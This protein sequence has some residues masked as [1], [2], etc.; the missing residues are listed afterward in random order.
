MNRRDAIKQTALLVGGAVSATAIAGVM[1]GCQANGSPDWL[2]RYLSEEEAV[3]VEHLTE[4]IL[5]ASDTPGA[6]DVHVAE[7]IDIMLK[8][9]YPTKDQELFKAGLLD[10]DKAA[11]VAFSKPFGKCSSD[12]HNKL[13]TKLDNDAFDASLEKN[14]S[15][16]SK[17]Y[18]MLKELTLLG[19]F[20]S[21]KV[22]T[23]MLDYH[24]IPTKYET[25]LP[26]TE[27]TRVYEDDNV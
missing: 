13:I 4:V 18:R 9:C 17:F 14:N 7:F 19:Y 10:L 8:D 21:E 26:V 25:C 2:P 15:T 22:M 20:T 23:T 6:K 16:Q 1:S 12:E 11:Q 5:P 3:L 27:A 24:P